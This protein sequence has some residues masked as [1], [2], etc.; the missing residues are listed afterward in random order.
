VSFH[1]P[2]FFDDLDQDVEIA[3]KKALAVIQTITAS[4]TDVMLPYRASDLESAR[5][6]VRAAERTFITLNG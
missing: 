4:M 5:G 6:V 1:F 2:Y 3:T